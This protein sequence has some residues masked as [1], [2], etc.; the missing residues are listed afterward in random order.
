M[1]SAVIKQHTL[2]Y[3]QHIANGIK[4]SRHLHCLA[5]LLLSRHHQLRRSVRGT[6]YV[7]V[8]PKKEDF[9]QT[10]EM[11]ELSPLFRPFHQTA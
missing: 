11:A 1:K 9:T 10:D 8:L 4:W 3:Y 6:E 7:S 2:V 5:R